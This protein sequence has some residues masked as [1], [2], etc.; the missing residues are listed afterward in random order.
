MTC[1]FYSPTHCTTIQPLTSTPKSGRLQTVL[2]LPLRWRVTFRPRVYVITSRP[3][4]YVIIINIITPLVRARSYMLASSRRSLLLTSARTSSQR[5]HEAENTSLVTVMYCQTVLHSWFSH[6]VL[7]LI[8][9][10][11]G[12]G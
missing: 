10:I 12:N 6:S 2:K 8:H 9:T 1:S 11:H 4:I 3:H 5:L 7:P